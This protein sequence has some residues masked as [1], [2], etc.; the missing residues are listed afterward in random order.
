MSI[1]LQRP[2]YVHEPG[3]LKMSGVQL[4]VCTVNFYVI[5]TIILNCL[6]GLFVSVL[7]FH[8]LIIVILFTVQSQLDW[9]LLAPETSICCTY[10]LPM[11]SLCFYTETSWRPVMTLWHWDCALMMLMPAAWNFCLLGSCLYVSKGLGDYLRLYV[12]LHTCPACHCFVCVW[13]CVGIWQIWDR[14]I[15]I[16]C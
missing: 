2:G 10:H 14:T 16:L 1:R 12:H 8:G 3:V 6:Y 15:N 7:C 13:V 4:P 9:L 5:I 11:K